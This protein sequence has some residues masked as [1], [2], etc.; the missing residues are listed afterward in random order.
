MKEVSLPLNIDFRDDYS[1]SSVCQYKGYTYVGMGEGSM[2]WINPDGSITCPFLKLPGDVVGVIVYQERLHCLADDGQHHARAPN[3]QSIHVYDL[4]GIKLHTWTHGDRSSELSG[5]KLTI[6]NDQLIVADRSHK[7]FTIYTL[8]GKRVNEEKCDLLS[9]EVFT[10]IC[11]AG[12]ESVIVSRPIA[13]PGLFKVNLKLGDVEWTSNRVEKPIGVTTF[14][15]DYA[16]V[17]SH[18]EN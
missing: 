17:I 1:P 8:K 11:H 10:T 2:E 14:S 7:N 3:K 4:N 12:N 9:D 6:V 18:E 16:V 13:N 5:R 15:K